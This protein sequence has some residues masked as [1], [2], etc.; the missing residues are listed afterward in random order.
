MP[1]Q[2]YLL[3]DGYNVINRVTE[4][5][6]SPDGGLESARLR[7][8]LRVSAW[9]RAYP[10]TVCIIV[11]DGDQRHAGGGDQ[12]IAGIRCIFSKMSHGG[13]DDIIRLAKELRAKKNDV[14]VV[15]DDNKVANNCRAHGASVQPSNFIMTEKAPPS[16][17]TAKTRKDD[18]GIDKKTA[19]EL[20]KELRKKFGL[21]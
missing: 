18:K 5:R 15:S 2:K 8:A 16:K 12:R 19:N 7:L 9:G 17:G 10:G 4:L 11:F 14:A 13:D 21:E 6:P 3:I 1:L 20:D